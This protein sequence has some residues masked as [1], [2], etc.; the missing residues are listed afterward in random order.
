LACSRFEIFSLAESTNKVPQNF[1]ILGRLNIVKHAG[2]WLQGAK[3]RG[4]QHICWDGCMFPNATLE[5]PRTWNAILG[6]MLKVRDAH[7]WD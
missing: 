4:M 6:V 1:K 7:G 3:D 5:D 2:P